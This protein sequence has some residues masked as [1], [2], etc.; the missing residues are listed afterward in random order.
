MLS[1]FLYAFRFSSLFFSSCPLPPLFFV[2]VF[3]FFLSL[4]DLT[5]NHNALGLN[6]GILV[7]VPIPVDV[8]S[9]QIRQKISNVE[10]AISKALE[11]AVFV[12]FYSFLSRSPLYFIRFSLNSSMY[13]IHSDV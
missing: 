12:N 9:P 8:S 2:L 6:S 11:D 1:T 10:A 4:S 5:V 13:F 3:V 7:T